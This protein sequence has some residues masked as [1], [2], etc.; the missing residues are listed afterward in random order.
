MIKS[1]G[2]VRNVLSYG[3]YV[4]ADVVGEETRS[5]ACLCHR[6]DRLVLSD[7]IRPLLENRD[8]NDRL[9]ELKQA[10]NCPTAQANYDNCVQGGVAAPITRCPL[11]RER[12]RLFGQTEKNFL[13]LV[14]NYDLIGYGRMMQIISREWYR[15]LKEK[16]PELGGGGTIVGNICL[17]NM[18][19]EDQE[20][21]V[22][23]YR[24]DP[25]FQQAQP[26]AEEGSEGM[27]KVD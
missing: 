26:P 5:V 25:L 15:W 14:R 20:M 8:D 6:C 10:F 17:A 18:T 11:Y 19:E 21:W 27:P 13:T 16:H 24:A 22:S 1:K 3:I 4:V 2:I 9:E 12:K 7:E 23:G